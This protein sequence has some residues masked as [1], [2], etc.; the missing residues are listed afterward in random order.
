MLRKRVVCVSLAVLMG[1][2]LMSG[3][4][5]ADEARLRQLIGRWEGNV[6]RTPT[7]GRDTGARVLT[8]RKIEGSG[9]ARTFTG[10]YAGRPVQGQAALEDGKPVLVFSTGGGTDA[11][12]VLESDTVLVGRLSGTAW[13]GGGVGIRLEKAGK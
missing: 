9:D 8:I 7:G 13:R 5:I 4:S 10:T 3:S 2:L 11:R 12:L 1:V 6:E